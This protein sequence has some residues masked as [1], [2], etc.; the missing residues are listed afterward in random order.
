MYVDEDFVNRAHGRALQG[1]NT[2]DVTVDTIKEGQD[3]MLENEIGP[4]SLRES[5]VVEHSGVMLS[6]ETWDE[7]PTP[8][9]L[10]DD[11]LSPYETQ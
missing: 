2:I 4:R 5:G 3:V 6:S 8:L 7:L 1:L 9:I 11:N 10:S